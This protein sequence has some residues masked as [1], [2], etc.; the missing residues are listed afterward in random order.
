MTPTAAAPAAVRPATKASANTNVATAA[1]TAKAVAGAAA[2]NTAAT[3]TPAAPAAAPPRAAQAAAAAPA[4]DLKSLETRLKSTSGIGVFTKITLKNQVDDLLDKFRS[5]YKGD[6]AASLA[7]LRQSYDQLVL[8]VLALLQDGDPPL[9]TAIAASR[10]S[11]WG[12]LSDRS[13]FAAV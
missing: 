10:E 1:A 5:F 12:V 11:I 3:T 8:K 9:A 6:L 2:T 13:K 7:Q 4:L